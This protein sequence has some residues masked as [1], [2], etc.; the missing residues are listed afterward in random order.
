[1]PGLFVSFFIQRESDR[2]R[3]RERETARRGERNTRE[4]ERERGRKEKKKGHRW[5]SETSS[6]ID[7]ILSLVLASPRALSS[8]STYQCQPETLEPSAPRSETSHRGSLSSQRAIASR[9][10]GKKYSPFCESGSAIFFSLAFFVILTHKS[11]LSLLLRF[12][13]SSFLLHTFL[14]PCSPSP[15]APPSLRALSPPPV[16]CPRAASPP[17]RPPAPSASSS[18][19]LTPRP[20][21]RPRSRRPR[22]PA[23]PALPASALSPGTR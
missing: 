23:S 13:I 2:S 17:P 20:R 11:I 7:S 5:K 16:P 21:S 4:R 15:P 19:R 1:M 12:C 10:R 6:T 22:T 9:D 14:Q 18:S 8:L 3:V